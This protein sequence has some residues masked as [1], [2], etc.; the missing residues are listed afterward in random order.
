[1]RKYYKKLHFLPED[2][3]SPSKEYVFMGFDTGASMHVRL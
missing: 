1:M 2:A 3:E